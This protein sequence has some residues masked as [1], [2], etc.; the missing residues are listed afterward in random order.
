M[1]FYAAPIGHPVARRPPYTAIERGLLP[2]NSGPTNHK[3]SII[4]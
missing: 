3:T 1:S 4:N 2:L